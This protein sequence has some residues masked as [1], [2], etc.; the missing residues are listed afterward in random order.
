MADPWYR[1]ADAIV[2]DLYFC[3]GTCGGSGWDGD[4]NGCADGSRE[5]FDDLDKFPKIAA[6]DGDTN[7]LDVSD[8]SA[9]GAF[10]G[11]G[12]HA[13][14]GADINL[15]RNDV[16]HFSALKVEDARSFAGCYVYNANNDCNQCQDTCGSRDSADTGHL[17][18]NTEER[19]ANGLMAGC[20]VSGGSDPDLVGIGAD[21]RWQDNAYHNNPA[22]LA[23]GR[24][25]ATSGSHNGCTVTNAGMIQGIV[26]C[27]DDYQVPAMSADGV[28]SVTPDGLGTM[29]FMGDQ[30]YL[31]RRSTGSRWHTANDEAKGTADE[32]GTYD[33]DPTAEPALFTIEYASWCVFS[34]PPP[35]CA[36]WSSAG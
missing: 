27:R 2:S 28:A 31:V 22:C 3:E 14:T 7:G 10:C 30:W 32:Y 6:C 20:A 5:G 8:T 17:I 13:C 4:A 34:S 11:A 33:P 23:D 29:Q 21:C 25:R 15:G 16:E 1:P 35:Q 24:I 26:C 36:A 9:T 19:A 12:W 18:S